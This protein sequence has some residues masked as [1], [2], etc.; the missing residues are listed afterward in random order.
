M[1]RIPSFVV[2]CDL[3]ETLFDSR[4]FSIEAQARE[5]FRQI[6]RQHV[7]VVLC[8]TRTRAELERI[9]QELGISQPFVCEAGAALFVPQSYFGHTIADSRHI[10]GYDVVEFGRP[11]A[12]IALILQRTAARLSV[13]IVTFSDMS[14][15]DVALDCKLPMM[16][17]RLAKLREYSE[18]FRFVDGD[19]EAMRRFLKALNGAGLECRGRGRYY[20]VA[21]K[22]GGMAAQRLRDLYEKSCGEVM[23]AAYGD[24]GTAAS[25]LR[26]A[27]LP[28]V[29]QSADVNQARQLTA[30][31]PASHLLASLSIDEWAAM[32][33][34]TLGTIRGYAELQARF[35]S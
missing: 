12:D 15:E 7:P 26:Q 13:G 24:H 35:D 23:A 9:Q 27:E 34:E 20:L 14:V 33:L 21:A 31:V 22:C 25:L 32:I 2:F 16:V 28:L 4:T 8:S 11:H 29:V 30:D 18:Q 3:D 6:E 17:A 5:A 19:Q 1:S 10:A